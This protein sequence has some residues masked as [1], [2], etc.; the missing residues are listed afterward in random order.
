MVR[1]VT[2]ADKV[3]HNLLQRRLHDELAE[4]DYEQ[5]LHT[6]QDDVA[7]NRLLGDAVGG[8]IH[9][10]KTRLFALGAVITVLGDAVAICVE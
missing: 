5:E 2:V 6:H 1:M 8:D 3:L 7:L 4:L 10:Q 9:R